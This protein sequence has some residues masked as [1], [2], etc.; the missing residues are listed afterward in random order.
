MSVRNGFVVSWPRSSHL[1]K[2]AAKCPR[3]TERP[4]DTKGMVLEPRERGC[5][6]EV[7]SHPGNGKAESRFGVTARHEPNPNS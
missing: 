5:L 6:A 4:S 2:S 7:K 3:A 1:L